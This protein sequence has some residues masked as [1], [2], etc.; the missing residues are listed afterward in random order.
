MT[1]CVHV[2]SCTVPAAVVIPTV[3]CM[4]AILGGCLSARLGDGDERTSLHGVKCILVF[5]GTLAN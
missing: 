4:G 3:T 1:V 5:E 2:G